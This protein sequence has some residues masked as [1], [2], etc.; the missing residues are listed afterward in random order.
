MKRSSWLS[1]ITLS[2]KNK[3][4]LDKYTAKW[5]KQGKRHLLLICVAIFFIRL[6]VTVNGILNYLY[7][8]APKEMLFFIYTMNAVI[9]PFILFDVFFTF[10]PKLNFLKGTPIIIVFYVDLGEFV[11]FMKI[12]FLPMM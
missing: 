5:Q 6:V 7:M 9:L 11:H 2:F 10:C 1:K 8:G 12:P 4:I 3:D